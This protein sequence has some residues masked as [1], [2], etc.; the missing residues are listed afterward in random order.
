[1]AYALSRELHDGERLAAG[2]NSP[3]ARAAVLLAHLTRGPNMRVFASLTF[4]NFHGLS[5]VP[6]AT[7]AMDDRMTARAEAF[8][9]HDEGMDAIRLLAD[10]FF[11]GALQVDRYGNSNLIGLKGPDGALR[12]RGPG[13]HA[14]TTMADHVKRYY[15]VVERHSPDVFVEGCDYVSCVGFGRPDAGRGRDALGLPGGGPALCV[16]PLACLDFETPDRSMRLRSVHPGV[17]VREVV[18]ATGFRLEVPKRV[19]ITRAP[20]AAELR[21]LREVADRDGE[22]RRDLGPGR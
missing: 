15:I 3:V 7:I 17:T 14:T 22:L 21:V 8:R 13:P 6:S 18:E 19:P 1:M 20:S 10:A 2:S 4:S 12:W 9:R 16:T 5:E 11:V